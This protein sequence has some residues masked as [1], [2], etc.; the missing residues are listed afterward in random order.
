MKTTA[1]AGKPRSEKAPVSK[2]VSHISKR[3]RHSARASKTPPW[4]WP[5]I[6]LTDRLANPDEVTCPHC[7]GKASFRRS[8]CESCGRATS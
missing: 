7:N 5:P 2:S 8:W 3:Q 4:P 1:A 6:R